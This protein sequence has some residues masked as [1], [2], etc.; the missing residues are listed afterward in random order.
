MNNR[1][2]IPDRLSRSDTSHRSSLAQK[3]FSLPCLRLKNFQQK[4]KAKT[5]FQS[6]QQ[7]EE[8]EHICALHQPLPILISMKAL[9]DAYD[10]GSYQSS[11]HHCTPD[12]LH[13]LSEC[14][15]DHE[16]SLKMKYIS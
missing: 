3:N 10:F 1:L 12:N 16:H 5:S 7:T 6:I 8:Y 9:K 4:T 14:L 11:F 15:L 13:S 2:S